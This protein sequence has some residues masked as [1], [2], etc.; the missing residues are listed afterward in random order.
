ME[1]KCVNEQIKTKV[2]DVGLLMK[3]K[4]Y[5]AASLYDEIGVIHKDIPIQ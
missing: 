5:F 3:F 1:M 2:Y 4:P